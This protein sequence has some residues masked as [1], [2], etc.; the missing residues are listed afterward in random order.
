M[1]CRFVDE[2]GRPACSPPEE[3][4]VCVEGDWLDLGGWPAYHQ[5][6]GG[7]LDGGVFEG[8]M[9]NWSVRSTVNSVENMQYVS[10]PDLERTSTTEEVEE[11]RRSLR[12]FYEHHREK[13]TNYDAAKYTERTLWTG[14]TKLSYALEHGWD[15]N[16]VLSP[17]WNFTGCAYLGR[18]RYSP[19]HYGRNLVKAENGSSFDW[20]YSSI[21]EAFGGGA[22]H[23]DVSNANSTNTDGPNSAKKKNLFHH[24][25][26]DANYV[27][28][29]RGL[30][31]KLQQEKAE[32]LFP[33]LREFVPLIH[34]ENGDW[35]RK[36]RCFYRSTT[37]CE[38][39]QDED[40]GN[41][42][43]TI[44]RKAAFLSGCE[45]MDINHVT[46][47]FEN[48]QYAFPK[49]PGDDMLE[50]WSVFW[51]SVH[52]QPWVYEELNNLLLNI[53]CNSSS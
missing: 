2:G 51:D 40:I 28:Y 23:S 33:L 26:F 22:A 18:C 10:P 41:W 43:H 46:K 20:N 37:G 29:N 1:P 53:L 6:L 25:F 30:W 14:R 3:P 27:F 24:Q 13:M 31:G 21:V 49:P 19:E 16:D 12:S 32:A 17:G 50:Y 15:A 36:N 39:S 4:N 9:E 47:E 34:S 8:R 42:E 45:Y 11:D 52:Y 38:R 35:T 44:V 48:L 5:S 7:G